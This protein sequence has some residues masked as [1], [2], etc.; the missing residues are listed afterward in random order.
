MK[1]F[2]FHKNSPIKSI[3][4]DGLDIKYTLKESLIVFEGILSIK[5]G[6]SLKLSF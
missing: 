4:K 3:R 6:E 5:K 1:S 2:G